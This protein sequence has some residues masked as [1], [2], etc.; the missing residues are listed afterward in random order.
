MWPSRIDGNIAQP[1]PILPCFNDAAKS[2]SVFNQ[3]NVYVWIFFTNTV[4]YA[5]SRQPASNDA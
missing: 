2:I 5:K 1:V 3:I 4:G